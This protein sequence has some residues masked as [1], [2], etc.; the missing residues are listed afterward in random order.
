VRRTAIDVHDP[1][2][3]VDNVTGEPALSATAKQLPV[4]RR[5][6]TRTSPFDVTESISADPAEKSNPTNVRPPEPVGV[7]DGALLVPLAVTPPDTDDTP[8]YETADTMCP[9][10]VLR[11]TWIAREPAV[12]PVAKYMAAFD[13]F[14]TNDMFTPS[15]RAA[16]VVLPATNTTMVA[17][18]ATVRFRLVV[19]APSMTVELSYAKYAAVAVAV[20]STTA[21]LDAARVWR[22][23]DSAEPSTRLKPV[24][25]SDGTGVATSVTARLFEAF[26]V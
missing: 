12:R 4:V 6:F 18:A 26:R 16:L 8:V 23:R 20:L 9:D 2:D 21:E 25:V 11:S 17:F 5:Y 10:E 22:A 14:P 1:D 7:P 13:V 15:T 19:D 24:A 3:G